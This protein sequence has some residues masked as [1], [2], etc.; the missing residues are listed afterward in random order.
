MS[1]EHVRPAGSAVDREMMACG[2]AQ[3]PRVRCAY[4][5]PTV[6]RIRLDSIVRGGGGSV[7][8]SSVGTVG[9]HT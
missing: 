5:R 9:R 8:D 4:A 6:V 2:E 3:A 7:V 1:E